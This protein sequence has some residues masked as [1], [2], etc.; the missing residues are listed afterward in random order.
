MKEERLN[1]ITSAISEME[2]PMVVFGYLYSLSK[3]E[4]NWL[5]N[6]IKK[7]AK[8]DPEKDFITNVILFS[9]NY[10]DIHGKIENNNDVLNFGYKEGNYE[11][12]FKNSR[13]TNDY[14]D[15]YMDTEDVMKSEKSRR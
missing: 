8:Y 2:G 11:D 5:I 3:D 4:Q 10:V 1:V 15:N 6:H 7:E 9:K 14:L 12:Y 13:F